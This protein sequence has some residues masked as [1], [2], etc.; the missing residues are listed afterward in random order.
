VFPVNRIP[1]VMAFFNMEKEDLF[2][3][4]ARK[5]GSAEGE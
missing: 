1:P 2:L 4:G 5:T 3:A